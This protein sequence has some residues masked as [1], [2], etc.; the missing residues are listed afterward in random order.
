MWIL[1]VAKLI[2]N[3]LGTCKNFFKKYNKDI[4]YTNANKKF[5]GEDERSIER[6]IGIK[7]KHIVKIQTTNDKHMKLH[8]LRMKCVWKR[9]NWSQK[10]SKTIYYTGCVS[11]PFSVFDGYM[12]SDKS[13]ISFLENNKSN[14]EKYLIT[15]DFK[16][17]STE[18]K[19]DVEESLE[20]INVFVYGYSE[21][22]CLSKLPCRKNIVLDYRLDKD[23]IVTNEYLN[24]VYRECI[25]LFDYLD[26]KYVKN[27]HLY[28]AARQ[29]V[30]FTVGQAIQKHHP[31]VYCY[32]YENGSYTWKIDI[33]EG[34]I[35][36]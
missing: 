33:K 18:V 20:D 3:F 16:L 8:L 31:K 13:N 5:L 7:G 28:V 6:E 12:A 1:E 23:E 17:V 4:I 15:S 10:Y 35:I 34:K 30:A 32:E 11:V 26:S 29:S 24:K 25:E 9:I 14:N 2:W 19:Y 21:E 36:K 22:P 27:I